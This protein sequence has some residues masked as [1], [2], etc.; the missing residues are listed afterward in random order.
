LKDIQYIIT[1][2]TNKSMAMGKAIMDS[3]ELRQIPINISCYKNQVELFLDKFFLNLDAGLE[4]YVG[5]YEG[6]NLLGGA[7]YEGNIIK[8]VALDDSLRGLGLTNTLISDLIKKIYDNG[9]N[10]AILFTK[11]ENKELFEGSGFYLVESSKMALLMETDKNAF[12]NYLKKLEIHKKPG[13][14]GAIVMNCNPFTLGH[15]HLV[16]YA[17]ARC[18]VLHLFVVEEDKSVFPFSIRRELAKKGVAH[19]DNVQIHNGGDYIISSATFPAY[20]I[21]DTDD[22][23]RTQAELDLRIFGGHIAPALRITKRFVGNEPYSQ[24]TNMYN[25]IMQEIL[26]SFGVEVEIVPRKEQAG[27]PIS[28]SRVREY[29]QN[30]DLYKARELL[31]SSTYSFLESTEAKQIIQTI[32]CY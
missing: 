26:P 4:Y 28:A 1:S 25:R 14:V 20:F 11:P 24:V 12:S 18:D 10:K 5:I 2:E 17:A 22:I 8:C 19:L 6:E 27:E 21:K 7:G 15:Q 31:P 29:I 23:I 30:G 3:Y 13:T 32:K 9:N 16:E